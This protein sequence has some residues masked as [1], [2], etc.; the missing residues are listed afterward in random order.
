MAV[1]AVGITV[2]SHRCWLCVKPYSFELVNA[3]PIVCAP[4]PESPGREHPSCLL[5]AFQGCCSLMSLAGEI[6]KSVHCFERMGADIQLG[7]GKA[8]SVL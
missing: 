3:A 1:V 6:K 4:L 2:G 5:L 8:G 7:Q